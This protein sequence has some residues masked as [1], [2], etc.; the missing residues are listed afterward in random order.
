MGERNSCLTMSNLGA[1]SLPPEM[2][3]YVARMDFIIGSQATRPNNM[4]M[5]SYGDKLYCNFIRNIEE[6]LLEREFF[7]FLRKLGLHVKV[8]SN[9]R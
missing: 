3:P 2:A 4:G 9:Q 7:V 1:V 8:E 5:L 6:P